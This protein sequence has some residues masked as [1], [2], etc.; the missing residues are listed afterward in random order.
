[1]FSHSQGQIAHF[2]PPTSHA[3]AKQADVLTFNKDTDPTPFRIC[4]ATCNDLH[5]VDSAVVVTANYLAEKKLLWPVVV[6][7]TVG[8]IWKK[9]GR[10]MPHEVCIGNGYDRGYIPMPDGDGGWKFKPGSLLYFP[11]F[12]TQVC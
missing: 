5:G 12:Q 3:L 1:M 7:P 9:K 8:G 6:L 10:R 11:S 2:G 4:C